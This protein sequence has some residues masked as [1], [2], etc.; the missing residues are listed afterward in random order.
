MLLVNGS[1]HDQSP[2]LPLWSQLHVAFTHP[3]FTPWG[4][5]S[6]KTSL[7]QEVSNA[8]A[9]IQEEWGWA[10]GKGLVHPAH[11]VAPRFPCRPNP[12]LSNL[13]TYLFLLFLS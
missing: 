10:R 2:S 4:L 9:R 11:E 7:K 12:P 13:Q 1:Q 3:D 6:P 5:I 8:W